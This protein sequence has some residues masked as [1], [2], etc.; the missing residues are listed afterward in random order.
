MASLQN[1]HESSESEEES[2]DGLSCG[3]SVFEYGDD[4][5]DNF[6]SDDRI[7]PYQFEPYALDSENQNGFDNDDANQQNETE[8]RLADSDWYFLL[9]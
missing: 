6:D 4:S 8:D 9:F 3:S 7:L 1:Q 2:I 5:E